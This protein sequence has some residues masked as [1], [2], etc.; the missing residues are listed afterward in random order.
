MNQLNP[1]QSPKSRGL[2]KKSP[3]GARK[4]QTLTL[5]SLALA[6]ALAGFAAYSVFF[7]KDSLDYLAAAR[8]K[9]AKGDAGAAVIEYKNALQADPG[10]LEARLLLGKL[11]YARNKFDAAEKELSAAT[12]SGKHPEVLPLLARTLMQLNQHKRLLEQIQPPVGAAL[13]IN[14]EILAL[15]ARAQLATGDTV[16]YEMSQQLADAQ[17]LNHPASQTNKAMQLAQHGHLNNALALIDQALVQAPKYTDLL[18]FKGDLLSGL[19]RVPEAIDA[20][21]KAAEAEPGNLRALLA[22]ANLN[23]QSNQLDRAAAKLKAAN[24]V[25]PDNL[26]VRYQ[27]A[28]LE[29]RLGHAA[30]A[31]TKIQDVLKAAPDFVP[32]RL[33]AGAAAL[34]GGRHE[35]AL[36]DLEYVVAQSPENQSARKLLAIIKMQTGQGKEA[37]ALLSQLDPKLLDD[38]MLLSAQAD[39][40]MRNRDFVE[41]RRSLERAAV[42][43]PAQ[44]KL[45][46]ELAASQIASGDEA[47]AL[48]SL[49]RAV[50]LDKTGVTPDLFLIQTHIKAKRHDA[51]LKAIDQLE[52]KNPQSPVASNLRGAVAAAKGDMAQ[53]RMQFE[54]ALKLQPAYLPA[55]NNLAQLD[56]QAK[57]LRSARQRFEQIIK[58]DPKNASAWISLAQLAGMQN[59]G[60]AYFDSLEKAKQVAPDG[61]Q[62]RELLIKYWLM[63]KD[64][65]R[66]ISESREAINA[67]GNKAFYDPLGAAHAMSGNKLESLAAY[68]KWAESA[69]ASPV[70][71]Y[72]LAV[73]QESNGKRTDALTALDKA[74]KLSPDYPDAMQ[75]KASLLGAQGKIDEALGLVR[76]FQK[77]HANSYVGYA[78]EAEV[79]MQAKRPTEA[80]KLFERA[81][82]LSGH[83]MFLVQSKSAYVAAGQ[84]QV[85]ERVLSDWLAKHPKDMLVKHALAQAQLDSGRSKEA[86]AH[87][88]WLVNANPNDLIA[89]NNL[90]WVYGNLG[91]ARAVT[92]AERAL[93]LQPN[94]A[95]VKDTLGWLLVR[96]GGVKQGVEYL[97]Q[98]VKAQPNAPE[99][100]IHLA[101]GLARLG[102]HKEALSTLE[103]LLGSGRDFPQKNEAVR[104]FNE[105][106]ARA[107]TSGN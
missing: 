104:L 100:G 17:Q 67:T 3:A 38:P 96:S 90:A 69:P 65:A 53:A 83:G 13:N 44:P 4:K 61:G 42:L 35:A 58:I 79:Q 30:V 81:A 5:V 52:K 72:R 89:L 82:R 8:S 55:A 16:G 28:M 78:A 27:D 107:A 98:A 50:V 43:N 23:M 87:Y 45:L 39:L 68:E 85:G 54:R 106:K 24:A 15:R 105:I 64:F 19:K 25:S 73:A 75:A 88:E 74:L 95:A 40:A 66:A 9:E 14:A 6:A 84:A 57:D 47:A 101:D 31:L 51:A 99:I 36:K 20:Y 2:N 91:D 63:K 71:H 29:F 10:N 12:K 34:A 32:A 70:A 1:I 94:N 18:L 26:I 103:L 76:D 48:T 33:L 49:E 21:D 37:K 97:R 60:K 93:K 77:R 62:A 59:D 86:A 22:S 41:A 102:Q 46:T 56:V 80:A 11:Y 7:K 92:T